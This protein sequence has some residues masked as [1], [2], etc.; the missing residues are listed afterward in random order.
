MAT[1]IT[2]DEIDNFKEIKDVYPETITKSYIE[3]I[4]RLDEREELEPFLRAILFDINDT[5][6]GPAELVDIFTHRISVN[7]INGMAGLIIKGKSFTKVKPSDVSHQIY[8][9]EKIE[10]LKYAIFAAT[11]IILDAAKEQ[12]CSTAERLGCTYAIFD[13]VDIA[14]LLIAYGFFCPRDF[15]RISAGRCKC[16]FSPKKRILNV[17]Q[18]ESLKALERAHNLKQ[19]AGLVVLPPGSGKTRIAAEDAKRFNANSVLYVAHTH[20]ILEVA[21]SEFEAVFGKE[22]VTMHESVR[23]L[24]KPSTVNISTIQLI[25]RN[26][27]QI[28]FNSFDYLVVDE[29]HHAAARSYRKLLEAISPEFLLGL[30]ATPFRGDRQDILELCNR[31]LLIEFELRY[32]IDAGILAPYHYYGCFDN[33][34][35]TKIKSTGT[36]YDVRDLEKALIIPERDEAIIERWKKH[37]D[38]KPTLAFC[39]SHRHAERMKKSFSSHN[40]TAEVYL[41]NT[42]LEHRK[43]LIEKLKAGKV[44]VLVTVDVVNEGA[45]LPFV[46]CLLFL[47]PTESQR[48]FYQQ[49][50]RGLRRYVGKSHCIVIDF[51]GNFKNAFKIVDWQGLMSTEEVA[52]SLSLKKS[53]KEIMNLPLGCVV[54]FDEKVLDIFARQ[55]FDPRTATRHNIARILLLQYEVL[56]YRLKRKPMRL[57]IRRN[58]YLGDDFYLTVFGSWKNFERVVEGYDFSQSN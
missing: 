50:G 57:D 16:G 4:R 17:F 37:A 35:Y 33:I 36:R 45:D 5:P 6:H 38:G 43:K 27:S 22:K 29:F 52:S 30:T 24:K 11:G 2:I 53:F 40:I 47:R 10:G 32:G 58:L 46:E 48:I 23:T 49:L 7:G 9:L 1:L 14:R 54:H 25:H 56:G 20:E 39:C 15:Q 42:G 34:D 41:S 55:S 18:D 44:K 19:Q 21:C 13:T 8:R 31:N 51:I 3:T 26:L 12:F 28:P